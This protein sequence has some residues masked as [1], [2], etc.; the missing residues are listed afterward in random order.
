[1]MKPLW[2]LILTLILAMC[3]SHARSDATEP[4]ADLPGATDPIGIA[5]FTGSKIVAYER[6]TYDEYVFATAGSAARLRAKLN[7]DA[8]AKAL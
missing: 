2:T 3:A 6:K 1:M 4:S 8:C 7:C 5:R